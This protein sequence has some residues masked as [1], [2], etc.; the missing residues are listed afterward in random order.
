MIRYFV[1]GYFVMVLFDDWYYNFLLI[2]L[3]N[4]IEMPHGIVTSRELSCE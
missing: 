4:L 1:R 3:I 2:N